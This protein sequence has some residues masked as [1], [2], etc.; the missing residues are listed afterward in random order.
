MLI[1][2]GI[3]LQ[4]VVLGTLMRSRTY[5]QD[6]KL[7]QVFEI[8]LFKDIKFLSLFLD[9]VCFGGS[10]YVVFG[11]ANQMA[12]SRG[13]EIKDSAYLVSVMGVCNVIGRVSSSL[14]AQYSCTNRVL[15]FAVCGCLCGIFSCSAALSDDFWSLVLTLGLFGVFFGAKVSQLAAVNMELFGPNILITT[16]GYSMFSFGVGGLAL[17]LL[18]S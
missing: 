9:G 3:A 14:I 11:M 1:L 17:P 10:V 15:Y 4:T 18:A 13:S 8:Y 12:I 6:L 16:I 7:R 5:Q 2:A